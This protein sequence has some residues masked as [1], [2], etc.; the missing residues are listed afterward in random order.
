MVDIMNNKKMAVQFYA[1][2]ELMAQVEYWYKSAGIP[3]DLFMSRAIKG[4]LVDI[5]RAFPQFKG[6]EQ[7][8]IDRKL[9]L[10]A[11]YIRK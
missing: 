6:G 5:I 11:E 10:R 7:A 3:K 1:E 8:F 2:P 9:A 4:Y